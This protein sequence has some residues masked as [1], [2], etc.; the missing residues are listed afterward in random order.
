MAE[1]GDIDWRDGE[2]NGDAG[3]EEGRTTNTPIAKH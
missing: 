3:A 2:L 1:G